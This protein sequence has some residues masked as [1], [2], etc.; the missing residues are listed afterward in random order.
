MDRRTL[1]DALVRAAHEIRNDPSMSADPEQDLFWSVLR[2]DLYDVTANPKLSLGSLDEA[3]SQ[4]EQF[5]NTDRPA[6]TND[7][8]WVAD[9]LRAWAYAAV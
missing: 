4:L 3:D 6:S 2:D 1:A 8:V 5:V 7:L 9:T